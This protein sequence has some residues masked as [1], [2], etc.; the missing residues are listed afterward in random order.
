MKTEISTSIFAKL[1]WFL[2]LMKLQLKAVPTPAALC[3]RALQRAAGLAILTLALLGHMARADRDK[4]PDEYPD[5]NPSDWRFERLSKIIP[6][7]SL[8]A[9]ETTAETPD[10]LGAE[11][12][13]KKIRQY[14]LSAAAIIPTGEQSDP[15]PMDCR[16]EFL[17][18]EI[19][20]AR[21]NIDGI[22]SSLQR[23]L[24]KCEKILARNNDRSFFSLLQIELL[25]YKIENLEAAYPFRM[26][27]PVGGV[28]QGFIF[29]K[30]EKPRPW[31]IIKCG[32]FCGYGNDTRTLNMIMHLFDEGP[33]HVMV[34]NNN[35]SVSNIIQN[36]RVN[37]S[38]FFEGQELLHAAYWLK[39]ISPYRSNVHAIHGMGISLGGSASLHAA[40]LNDQNLVRG[41]KLFQSM[42]AYCP[43]VNTYPTYRDLFRNHAIGQLFSF[44]TWHILQTVY[45]HVDDLN[46]IVP[47]N[48][49]P[50]VRE[51]PLMLSQI[52]W[53]FLNQRGR[54][55]FLNPFRIDNPFTDMASMWAANNYKD[56]AQ[57]LKTPTLV[58]ASNDDSVVKTEINSHTLLDQFQTDPDTLLR[59]LEFQHGNHCGPSL[60]YGWK[61]LSQ[62]LRSFYLNYSN[63]N[64]AVEST[65]K[66][67]NFS[68]P[69]YLRVG[70]IIVDYAWQASHKHENLR[71]TLK[72]WSSQEAPRGCGMRSETSSQ[73]K[74][75]NRNPYT[76][77]RSCYFTTQTTLPYR[78]LSGWG[79]AKPKNDTEAQKL[80]RDL[81]ANL[82]LLNN[83]AP[84]YGTAKTPNQVR[85][86]RVQF[87]PK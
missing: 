56:L 47:L 9:V 22:A 70:E 60:V 34:L 25:K 78:L 53:R 19:Q 50:K 55:E 67:N 11:T 71:L 21:E 43:V 61:P 12:E 38:G 64:E 27:T 40:R 83:G 77:E 58:I 52:G 39:Y 32:V 6:A 48:R 4:L 41:E 82:E 63:Q 10:S 74:P 16:A 84:I 62:I 2:V 18:T 31:V 24:Q 73:R 29:V 45:D 42:I 65:L 54:D 37:V 75:Q 23:Y 28:L 35:M 5:F 80:T 7:D 15:V 8:I 46:Q 72:T 59:V 76:S 33:F 81:N 26:T 51:I 36:K 85:L 44:R 66:L 86:N 69:I 20:S 3:L 30:D 17:R 1:L 13:F 57:K 87:L 49:K 14:L 79:I 68:A